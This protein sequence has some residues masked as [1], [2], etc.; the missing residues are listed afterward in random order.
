MPA[1]RCS[2]SCRTGSSL[3]PG[4]EHVEPP[5]AA[6]RHRRDAAD[7]PGRAVLRPRLR[8]RGHA[9]VAPDPRRPVRRRCRARRPQT[10]DDRPAAGVARA[11]FLLLIVWWAWIYTTWMAN[12][13]DPAS[14]APVRG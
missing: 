12:W 8:L 14:S 7:D 10:T 6:A 11:A 3:A 4:S 13:F 5:P 2:T 9:A 1:G